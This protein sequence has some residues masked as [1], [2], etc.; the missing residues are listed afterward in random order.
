MGIPQRRRFDEILQFLSFEDKKQLRA[1]SWSL[2]HLVHRYLALGIN[3]SLG[4]KHIPLEELKIG[5]FYSQY[6]TRMRLWGGKDRSATMIT[7]I[8]QMPDTLTI[9]S[10]GGGSVVN[11]P[12]IQAL[13]RF[14]H[15][16]QLK[17]I[18]YPETTPEIIGNLPTGLTSLRLFS[19]W[20]PGASPGCCSIYCS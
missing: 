6:W 3:I 18:D 19:K 14:S 12:V 10:I 9:F 7:L 17:F 13:S 16:R 8:G 1:V 11:L 4:F 2:Y 15:L 20:G 5:G